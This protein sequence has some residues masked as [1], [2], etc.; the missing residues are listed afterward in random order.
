MKQIVFLLFPGFEMLDFAGP[1]RLL[2]KR[3]TA[4]VTFPLHTAPGSR[5]SQHPRAS[6]SIKS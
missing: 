4:G 6:S 2:P 5:K 3:K 1:F